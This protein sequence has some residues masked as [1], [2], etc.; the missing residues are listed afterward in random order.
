MKYRMA[1]AL[2]AMV[3]AA[4]RSGGDAT[5]PVRADRQLGALN[6]AA[7]S[8]EASVRNG[9]LSA[10]KERSGFNGAPGSFCTISESNLNE[11]PVGSRIY[12]LGRP[13]DVF[14]PAGTDVL[15]DVGP[16]NNTASGHCAMNLATSRGLCT[17]SGGTGKFQWFNA[18][19]DVS[20]P[21]DKSWHLNGSYYY[22]Q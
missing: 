10:V 16:G 4:G 12:S 9:S 14:S 6:S 5:A 15:L 11:I 3:G 1:V 18:S 8:A 22:G 21:V 19:L 13:L 7:S 20:D 2:T 17:F